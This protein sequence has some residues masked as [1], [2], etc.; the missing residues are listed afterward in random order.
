MLLL[1]GTVAVR[2]RRNG[3]IG[4]KDDYAG[5][6]PFDFTIRR[7]RSNGMPTESH[8]V[9]EGYGTWMFY[10]HVRGEVIVR[11]MF[12][13]LDAF[14]ASFKAPDPYLGKQITNTN[15][16]GKTT[17]S[18]FDVRK[19]PDILIGCSWSDELTNPPPELGDY[20]LDELRGP[21]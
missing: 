7:W 15:D 9:M 17:F 13:S 16:N 5:H 20:A 4:S 10:G 3:A 19:V 21:K 6:Y 8:K 12:L 18:V 11:W 14:R 2:L 1:G